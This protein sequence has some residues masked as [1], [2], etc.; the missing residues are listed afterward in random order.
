MRMITIIKQDY[1]GE[2]ILRYEGLLRSIS[3]HEVEIVAH[4]DRQDTPVDEIV[5][6]RGD[7]FIETY[8]DNRWYNI[9]DIHDQDSDLIKCWYCNISHPAKIGDNDISY[10]DLAIDLLIY[11]GGRQKVLD[12]E[13]FSRLPL[14][15]EVK[16]AALNALSELQQKFLERS[17]DG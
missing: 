2:E 6:R 5:L 16:E 14:T 17:H 7:L 12:M 9:Y 8:F 10:R 4:F 3:P 1:S 11:P 15:A 13:E